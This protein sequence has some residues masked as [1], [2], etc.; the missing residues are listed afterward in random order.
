M[1]GSVQVCAPTQPR[2]LPA[3]GTSQQPICQSASVN[4]CLER[5]PVGR[6]ACA[7]ALCSRIYV[8]PWVYRLPWNSAAKQWPQNVLTSTR[9]LLAS[10]QEVGVRMQVLRTKVVDPTCHDIPIVLARRWQCAGSSRAKL[11]LPLWRAVPAC[12]LQLPASWP[13]YV[14]IKQVNFPEGSNDTLRSNQLNARG[15]AACIPAAEHQGLGPQLFFVQAL[16]AILALQ[17]AQ[18]PIHRHAYWCRRQSATLADSRPA[19]W[20]SSGWN[21]CRW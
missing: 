10:S 12:K 8:G 15:I 2:C 1:A 20:P 18:V 5:A 6:C 19:Q 4:E 14:A 7:T 17:R 11:G 21:D 3:M 13:I 16:P 9:F